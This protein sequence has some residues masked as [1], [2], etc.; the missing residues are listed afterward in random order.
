MGTNIG[1]GMPRLWSKDLRTLVIAI[2]NG[3]FEYERTAHAKIDWAKYDEA[4]INEVAD[5]LHVINTSVDIAFERIKA[6]RSIKRRH[7]GRPMSPINDVVKVML[8]QSFFG[9]SNRVAAGFVR[10]IGAIRFSGSFSYKT[11]E[12]GYDPE[13][14]KELLDEV[15]GL[16]NEWSNFTETTAGV[17]G[18]GDPSSNKVNYEAKRSAQRKER[19]STAVK[20][21]KQEIEGKWP[22]KS[23]FQ[24]SVLCAGAHTKVIS[25][26]S[27]SDNRHIGELSHLP[28]VMVQTH[29]NM[30]SLD[31]VT[32]DALYAN[33]KSCKI[34]SSYGADLFSIPKSD[35][36]LRSR[37]CH[38]WSIM[39]Y[40]LILDPQG[41]LQIYHN[42][43]P[44][45]ETVNS[46]MKRREPVPIRKRL[47]WRRSTEE[48]LKVNIHNLRQSCYLTY[49]RPEFSRLT[50]GC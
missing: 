43:S 33:R 16:T 20:Q 4:Q 47:T 9:F 25:G 13:R 5:I 8:L 40:R 11:I 7:P 46:M 23:D 37:G 18:T 27:T 48:Y 3:T 19:K 32:G 2:R 31:I 29:I 14:T 26:F 22:G 34:V 24:Y 21:S 1:S 17:D 41:F 6:K 38:E 35:A 15:F 30:P 45:T 10:L 42:R 28:N 50:L 44:A 39:T 36:T 49:L 12:R